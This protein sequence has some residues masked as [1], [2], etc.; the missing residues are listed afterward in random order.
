MT[1]YNIYC[2]YGTPSAYV[3]FTTMIAP[4]VPTFMNPAVL[5]TNNG[6]TISIT[7][8]GITTDTHTGGY[9]A[10]SYEV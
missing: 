1:P 2:G 8:A 10:S 7:W 5:G 6:L 3:N 4:T 9:V